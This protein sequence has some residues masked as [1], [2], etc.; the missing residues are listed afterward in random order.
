MIDRQEILHQLDTEAESYVFPML[1]NGYYYH[2]DQKLTIFRDEKR[3]AILL[4]V[5]AYNNHEDNIDGI[6]TIA[7]VFGNCLT[8]WND[9]DNFN[10][11]ASNNGVE[12]FLYDETNYV[13]YLNDKAK[14]IKV[15]DTIIPIQ[16]EKEYYLDKGVEL[17]FE[18]KITPWEFMRGLIPEHSNLF[19][20]TKQEISKKIPIDLPEFMILTNWHHPDLVIG[21]K[22]SETET[23]QQLADVI[24]TGNKTLYNTTET[25]NTHWTNWPDGG[26]L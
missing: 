16:F 20:Q 8:G 7:N 3:W 10:F 25:I 2:G 17:E 24:A 6:T 23:F 9:N 26:N 14:S 1:D 15:R 4:E 22:P 13:P 18:N 11:F 5:L 21:E 19:W 12:T